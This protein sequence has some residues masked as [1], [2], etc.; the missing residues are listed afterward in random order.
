MFITN[1]QAGTIILDVGSN[2]L[3]VYVSHEPFARAFV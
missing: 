1:N 2:N 3:D